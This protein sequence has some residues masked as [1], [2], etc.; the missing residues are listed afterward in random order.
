MKKE[1]LMILVLI[2]LP[3]IFIMNLGAQSTGAVVNGLAQIR[4]DQINLALNFPYTTELPYKVMTY[5]IR[6]HLRNMASEDYYYPYGLGNGNGYYLEMTY[7]VPDL[8]RL[9]C[10]RPYED[11][12]ISASGR[13]FTIP[14]GRWGGAEFE[15][16]GQIPCNPA[17]QQASEDTLDKLVE[18]NNRLLAITIA[19][20][21]CGYLAQDS[22]SRGEENI[23]QGN[24]EAAITNWRNAWSAATTCI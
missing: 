12:Y 6:A 1:F 20:S 17:L 8:L 11:H 10:L 13:T 4:V 2:G 22:I 15:D 14:W 19:N 24:Y 23:A 7:L 3:T 21:R 9:A 18:L 16:L 5:R